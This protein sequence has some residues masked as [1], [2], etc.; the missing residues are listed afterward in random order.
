MKSVSKSFPA[1]NN[2]DTRWEQSP[3]DLNRNEQLNER[4]NIEGGQYQP[5][6]PFNSTNSDA[7]DRH[8]N[9]ADKPMDTETQKFCVYEEKPQCA[10]PHFRLRQIKDI[11]SVP[12]GNG[13]FDSLIK[14]TGLKMTAIELWNKLLV[15]P[16]LT[17]CGDPYGVCLLLSSQSEYGNH[18]LRYRT[19]RRPP[20]RSEH[21]KPLPP[22]IAGFQ[23][24]WG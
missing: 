9:P 2:F 3:N 10:Q 8:E 1:G 6:E 21:F 13:L 4:Q 16:A 22:I 18:G 15:S 19:G 7:R 20:M 23:M 11:P 24:E 5:P 12:K 17:D 14:I